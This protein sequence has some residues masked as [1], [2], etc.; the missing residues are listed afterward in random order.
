MG[1]EEIG[2]LEGLWEL[3]MS[4]L[5]RPFAFCY[6]HHD[7]VV[8]GGLL[9]RMQGYGYER[10]V[11]RGLGLRGRGPRGTMR[12]KDEWKQGGSP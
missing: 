6:C 2:K 8:W 3:P 10:K 7:R 11:T 9:G 12:D 5:E 1:V 4:I